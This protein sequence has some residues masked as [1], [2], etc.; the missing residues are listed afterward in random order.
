MSVLFANTRASHGSSSGNLLEFKAGRTILE[1]GSSPEKR[2]VVSDKTKGLV[3]IKQTPDQLVHF[4]WKN[5]EKNTTDLDLIIFPGDTEFIKIKECADGRMYMLKFK[6]CEDH[7][8]FWLQDSNT[9][10]DEKVCK[11][12]NDLLNNPPS[13]RASARGGSSE[14]NSHALSALTSAMGGDEMGALG[15]MDQNQIMQLFSLMNGGNP[16]MLPQLPLTT[17]GPS[18]ATSSAPA[19]LETP[20]IRKQGSGENVEIDAATLNDIFSNLPRKDKPYV[21]LAKVLNGPNLKD[22]IDKN[23]ADLLSHLPTTSEKPEKELEKSL[24][25]P[26]FQQ[27]AHWFGSALHSGQLG[28]VMRQFDLPDSA[29]KAAHS[30]D[31][32]HFGKELTIALN[33]EADKAINEAAAKEE[34]TE[35]KKDDPSDEQ[36]DLD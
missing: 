3:F 33:K 6:S 30:G 21:E 9:D 23:S 29:V 18:P 17:R 15:N 19:P 35:S 14:R 4:C 26:Q 10:K 12:V 7:K 5:R 8:L 36:M 1:T 27:T 32:V 13:N 2:K 28:E 11:K 24:T 31:I 20:K 22:T 25:S 34:N 16:D